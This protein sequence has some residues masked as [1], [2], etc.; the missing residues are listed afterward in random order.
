M[1]QIRIYKDG[2][3]VKVAKNRRV[4]VMQDPHRDDGA[5]IVFQ[6]YDP[7][8]VRADDDKQHYKYPEKDVSKL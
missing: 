2:I 4:T 1:K 8:V 3:K 5:M 6:K 7:S